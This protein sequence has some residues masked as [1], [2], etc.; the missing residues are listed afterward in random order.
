MAKRFAIV[1]F[2]VTLGFMAWGALV[3]AQHG[4]PLWQWPLFG[5]FLGGWI[6]LVIGVGALALNWIVGARR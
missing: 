3:V 1:C 2:V 4:D 6:P 5:L